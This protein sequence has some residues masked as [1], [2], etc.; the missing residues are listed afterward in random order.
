MDPASIPTTRQSYYQ[1]YGTTLRGLQE[2]FEID[3]YQ[4]LAYVHDI[5]ITDYLNPDP[6]L[7]QMLHELPQEKWIFT[8]SD[9]AHALRVLK[10]LRIEHHFKGIL[11]IITMGFKNKPEPAV[12]KLA[13]EYIGNPPVG[14]C[15]FADDSLKN[16]A[17]ATKLGLHT[18]LVGSKTV[19]SD[20]H[21]IQSIHQLPEVLNKII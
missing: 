14:R 17:P 21:H 5:P 9:K 19:D 1:Q 12:Y 11:D 2:N 4:Y 20:H 18:V 7:D 3:P 16:L 15:L 10:A 6:I 8:N 13:V